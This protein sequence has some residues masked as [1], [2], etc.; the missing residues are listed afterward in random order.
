MKKF[1]CIMCGLEERC[2]VVATRVHGD[3][4]KSLRVVDCVRCGHRQLHPPA[5]DLVYYEDDGQVNSVIN[6]YGTK[7]N[8]LIQHAWTDAKR[9]VYRFLEKEIIFDE[10]TNCHKGLDGGNQL[11]VLD[12]GGGYGFFGVEFRNRYPSSN[13]LTIEPSLKRVEVGKAEIEKKYP[14]TQAE[15]SVGLLDKEFVE[16]HRSEFDI[17]VAWHVLEHLTDPSDFVRMAEEV[18]KEGGVLC[19]EVP[20]SNDDLLNLSK[21]YRDRFYMIEHVSYFNPSNLSILLSGT[22]SQGQVN[23]AGHQRYGIYN[24]I[25][26][27]E[28]NEKQGEYPDLFCGNDRFWLE[29]NWRKV[30]E[31][32]MTTDALFAWKWK[33]Q[34]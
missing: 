16:N 5:Y 27:I 18:V 12:V 33:S 6:S 31:A 17:V 10:P 34:N 23:V 26:W 7:F 8:T 32:T 15:F 9:R 25:H 28:K 29:S 2:F 4:S 14:R 30:K 13:V 3:D 22:K 19:L 20:N 11:K 24:Y 1:N 21:A